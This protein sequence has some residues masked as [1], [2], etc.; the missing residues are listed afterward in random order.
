MARAH[1]YHEHE[2]SNVFEKLNPWYEHPWASNFCG[3]SH[4]FSPNHGTH[5]LIHPT[6][7]VR[8]AILDEND[9]ERSLQLVAVDPRT[10]HLASMTRDSDLADKLK[11]VEYELLRVPA[12]F[13]DRGGQVVYR[14]RCDYFFASDNQPVP[15]DICHLLESETI[16][17]IAFRA[18]YPGEKFRPN[19]RVATQAKALARLALN[20]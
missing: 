11:N 16:E 7:L 19:F 1:L 5:K 4:G 15:D 17:Q 13:P 8:P 10:R 3:P 6:T 18:P 12:H 9:A 2:E 14:D 20:C